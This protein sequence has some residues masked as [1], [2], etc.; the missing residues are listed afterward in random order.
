LADAEQHEHVLVVVDIADVGGADEV[1]HVKV[2][3]EGRRDRLTEARD[4]AGRVGRVG[5]ADLSGVAVS[6]G[7]GRLLGRR[8]LHE[9]RRNPHDNGAERKAHAHGHHLD[10]K[11]TG[12]TERSRQ[13]AA[14]V[15]RGD[16]HR[17]HR[18]RH[19]DLR[20]AAATA[21]ALGQGMEADDI[22]RPHDRVPPLRPHKLAAVVDAERGLVELEAATA[23]DRSHGRL[24]A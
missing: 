13:R 5:R 7:H 6:A 8:R 21:A 9:Q 17:D 4:V 15:G 3:P 2:E 18:E 1:G 20:S 10:A 24:V 12:D 19:D 22:T 16:H 23:V 11:R 14:D